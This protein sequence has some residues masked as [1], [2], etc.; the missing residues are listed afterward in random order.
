[1]KGKLI[2]TV[3]QAADRVKNIALLT[4]RTLQS[5]RRSLQ[6]AARLILLPAKFSRQK[7]LK[8]V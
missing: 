6:R 2:M 5:K 7:K 3:E 1:M 8:Q 4:Q